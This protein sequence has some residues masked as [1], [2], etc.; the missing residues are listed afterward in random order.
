MQATESLGAER[1]TT[2]R[3]LLQIARGDRAAGDLLK[4]H[5]VVVSDCSVRLA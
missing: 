3:G 1:L 4:G 2:L 5:C